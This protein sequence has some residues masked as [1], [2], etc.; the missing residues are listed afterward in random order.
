MKGGINYNNRPGDDDI[1]RRWAD[2]PEAIFKAI[3]NDPIVLD[4]VDM[5]TE[6]L[7][8]GIRS[9]SAEPQQRSIFGQWKAEEVL[10]DLEFIINDWKGAYCACTTLHEFDD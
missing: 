1:L 9:E 10:K 3:K 4:I 2:G 8:Q 5:A 6:Y 7:V